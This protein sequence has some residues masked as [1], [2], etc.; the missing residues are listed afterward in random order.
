MVCA[1]FSILL[2]NTKSP[3]IRRF[4]CISQYYFKTQYHQLSE[5]LCA[6]LNIT[7]KYNITNYQKV[8]AHFSILLQNTISNYQ[9]FC[10]YFSILLQNTKLPIIRW[11]VCISQYYIKIQYHQLSEGLFAFLNIT[12][13]YKITNY[14]KVCVHYSILLQN[15][16]SPI[17]GWFVCIS[18][19]Y[20]KI[21]YH[22]LSEGLF[23]FLNITSKYKITNYQ[24]V[25]V[26]YSILLQH[27]K[28]PIITTHS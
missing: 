4:V 25:C 12:S 22:Q 13:K 23:A 28:S 19:Y 10:A 17:I 9:K 8:C 15:T 26:H 1:L 3:I 11:F 18:Q 27:M 7:S 14:Q 16:K 6:F 5:G 21:Q 20:F 24:N 2:Q